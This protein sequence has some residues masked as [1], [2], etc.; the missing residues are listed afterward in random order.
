MSWACSECGDTHE[1]FPHTFTIES[2][3]LFNNLTD[4]ERENSD[5]SSD[6]CVIGRTGSLE[7]FVRGLI[8]IHPNDGGSVHF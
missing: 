7:F 3:M 8:H 4:A 2:A 1:D 5:L 6:Q